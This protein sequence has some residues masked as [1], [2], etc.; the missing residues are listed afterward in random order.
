M[1]E[2]SLRASRRR[3]Y[4]KKYKEEISRGDSEADKE[5]RKSTHK[6]WSAFRLLPVR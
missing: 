1:G 2:A 4:T 6:I 3:A 5:K